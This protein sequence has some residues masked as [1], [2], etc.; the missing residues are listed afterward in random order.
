LR[1]L[2]RREPLLDAARKRGVFLLVRFGKR[3]AISVDDT[4]TP[5][6]IWKLR[7]RIVRRFALLCFGRCF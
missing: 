3:K 4:V 5:R 1:R 7:R 2:R 6:R